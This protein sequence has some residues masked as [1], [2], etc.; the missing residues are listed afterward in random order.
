MEKTY[1]KSFGWLTESGV[2][3]GDLN[4]IADSPAFITTKQTISYPEQQDD[5]RTASYM[6][7]TNHNAPISF[8]M[9]NFHLLLLYSD[10][11]TVVSLINHQ[12]VHE[13]YFQ[14]QFGKL[15]NIIKDPLNGNVYCYSNKSIFRYKVMKF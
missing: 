15:L 10:H 6:S 7:R 12:I 2:M 5:L 1:P 14:D 11:V 9:T 13:E 3:F 8:V 4:Q